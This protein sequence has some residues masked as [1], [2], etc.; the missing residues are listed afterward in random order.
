LNDAEVVPAGTVTVGGTNA[1]ELFDERLTSVSVAD[2]SESMIVPMDALPPVT[3]A[4][5]TFAARSATEP[6]VSTPLPS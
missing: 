4:G 2:A 5:A 3:L 6:T 1:D